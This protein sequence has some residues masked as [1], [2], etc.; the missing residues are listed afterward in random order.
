MG[1]SKY[2]V[3]DPGWSAAYHKF[4]TNPPP[5]HPFSNNPAVL[6][7]NNNET[8]ALFSDYGSG[9]YEGSNVASTISG[10]IKSLNPGYSIHLGD[11]YYSGSGDEYQKNLLDL[12]PEGK[13]GNFTMNGN[14]DM[15]DGANGYFD[16]ALKH[17]FFEKQQGTSYFAFEND[18]W[19][20][21]GLDTSY[22]ADKSGGYGYGSLVDHAQ[23]E[24]LEVCA[25]KKKNIIIL[26]HHNPVGY[27]GDFKLYLW[28]DVVDSVG[29]YLKYWYYGHSHNGVVYKDIDGI[30]CRLLGHGSLLHGETSAISESDSV[31]WYE[32]SKPTIGDNSLRVQNGFVRI[33]LDNDT[34][35]EEFY[36]EDG[37]VHFSL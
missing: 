30:K 7:I 8:L 20:V 4:F 24:F 3:L 23:K 34:L 16:V 9:D 18:Y 12:W 29:K 25:T 17:P 26:T 1:Y 2:T 36:G 15:L 32:H 33:T 14:H 5:V 21:V 37:L 27:A 6:K 11:V 22:Y 35:H 13:H 19:V 31:I 28:N 10:H